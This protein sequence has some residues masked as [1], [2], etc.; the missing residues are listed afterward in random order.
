[1]L[2]Y[3]SGVAA[4]LLVTSMALSACSSPA[5]EPAANSS[6]GEV[7]VSRLA[8]THR[9]GFNG[10]LLDP[11][12]AAPTQPLRDTDGRDFVIAERPE[13][14]VTVLFFGYTHCPDVCPTT[15]ADL[16]TA[17]AAMSAPDR[18]KVTVLFV[19]ED[20]ERDTPN[21][22]RRWLDGFDR[23]FV[24]LSGGNAATR[25]M[26]EDLYL[27]TTKRLPHPEKGIKHP[28]NGARHHEHG[29]YGVEHSGVVYAFGPGDSTV[30]YTGNITPDEYAADFARLLHHTP[31]GSGS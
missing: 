7:P 16:A 10:T 9:S 3:P 13:D 17:R 6:F 15:L 18:D 12:V 4:V 22:L 29:D 14:G 28:D 2:G 21:A 31:K 8:S 11:P 27:P 24:G 25:Q 30:I 20:P 19:T 1:M 23:S 5:R 26:L